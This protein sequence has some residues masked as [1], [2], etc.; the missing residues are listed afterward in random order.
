MEAALARLQN[1]LA[2]AEEDRR[3]ADDEVSCLTDERV[4]LLLELGTYKDEISAI[5]AEAVRENVALREAYEGGLDVIFNY[6]Y[7]AA[8]SHITSVVAT[9][10][11]LMGC[12]TSPSRYLQSFL[13]ILDAP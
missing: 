6:W 5:W 13:L 9:P 7:G 10:K 1:A 3:K 2:V 12:R 8:L 4:S 11:F